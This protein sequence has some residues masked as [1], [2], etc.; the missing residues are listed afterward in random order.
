MKENLEIVEQLIESS[1]YLVIH[2]TDPVDKEMH[3]AMLDVVT[4]SWF[5]YASG[6]W[7]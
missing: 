7:D 3:Q 4:A 2:S 5:M 1:E 6:N